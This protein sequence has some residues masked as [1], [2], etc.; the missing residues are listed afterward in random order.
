MIRQLALASALAL[1]TPFAV[2]AAR[3]PDPEVPEFVSAVRDGAAT[4]D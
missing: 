2:S 4:P 3:P 1:A